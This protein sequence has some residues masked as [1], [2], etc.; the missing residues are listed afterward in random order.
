MNTTTQSTYAELGCRILLPHSEELK[1]YKAITHGYDL[2]KPDEF[3]MLK[4]VIADLRKGWAAFELVWRGRFVEV[5]RPAAN[6]W[7]AEKEFLTRKR[8]VG[9]SRSR[10]K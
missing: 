9:M 1:G 2:G 3:A 10:R 7:N 5:W 4:T 6:L 8:T